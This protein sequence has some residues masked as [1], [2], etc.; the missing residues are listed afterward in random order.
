M[1]KYY[2]YVLI[3]LLLIF[4]LLILKYIIR[5]KKIARAKTL[6]SS[7]KFIKKCFKGE[8]INKNSKIIVSNPKI[9]AIIPVFNCQ[10]TILA[11]IRSIQ[12]QNMADIEIIL[13]NDNSKDNTSIIIKKL[14]EEDNR[15]K[16]LNNEKNM[17]TLYSRN[18][19]ILM[20]RGKYIMNL[21]NDDLFMYSDVFSI[22]YNE[23]E[24]G[25]YDIIGFKAV[26]C[27]TYNPSII[28]MK[29]ALY[30]SHIEGLTLYQPKLT[31]FAISSGNKYS[32]ND[33]HVWGRLTKANLY[34]KVIHNFGKNALGEI[35][36]LCFVTWG[37]DSSISMAIFRYAKSYKYIKKYGL[38]HFIGMN[39]SS[40]KSNNDLKIYGELFFLDSIIDFS[41]NNF[42]GKKYSIE[43]AKERIFPYINKI[44]SDKNRKY[45]KAIFCK[46]MKSKYIPIKFKNEIENKLN[47][48]NI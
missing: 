38:F 28:Q 48:I 39:T 42:K 23:A 2:Y 24:K 33:L 10:N 45:L 41:H 17:A 43:M 14:A 37:E 4:S 11:S 22:V 12:N 25:N 16:I 6:Y 34:K 20:S 18:I 46:M 3:I 30:H 5:R 31:Y 19:G 47:A 40:N 1:R 8:L 9:S 13:V 27:P 44:Y 15:I 36:N 29:D 32:Q 21:D 7:I 35:R 26:D